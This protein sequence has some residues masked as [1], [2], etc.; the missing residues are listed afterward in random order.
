MCMLHTIFSLLQIVSEGPPTGQ[1]EMPNALNNIFCVNEVLEDI[2]G[3]VDPEDLPEEEGSRGAGRDGGGGA[4]GNDMLDS[5]DGDD[6]AT[7]A[8]KTFVTSCPGTDRGGI[9]MGGGG[10]STTQQSRQTS[11]SLAN[12]L[13]LSISP[14]AEAHQNDNRAVMCLYLQQ[15]WALEDTIWTWEL[16]NNLLCQELTNLQDKLQS[17]T[18]ELSR[19]ERQAD[20]LQMHLEMLEM[21]GTH[22]CCSSQHPHAHCKSLLPSSD[23]STCSSQ[24]PWSPSQSASKKMLSHGYFKGIREGE[25]EGCVLRNGRCR[26]GSIAHEIAKWCWWWFPFWRIVQMLLFL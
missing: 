10:N 17:S 22:H 14:D 16:Q 19:A 9:S 26:G 24:F 13:F 18:H 20:K 3:L 23:G 2:G 4:G 15:I 12:K 5:N 25:G 1:G 8:K 6:Y 7:P 21:M 11:S